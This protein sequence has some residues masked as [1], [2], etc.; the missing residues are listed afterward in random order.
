MVPPC[1]CKKFSVYQKES[2]KLQNAYAL[3]LR[4][5]NR[6]FLI[7]Q[8]HGK[9][10][11]YMILMMLYAETTWGNGGEMTARINDILC[12][13]IQYSEHVS[14]RRYYNIMIEFKYKNILY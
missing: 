4:N 8:T 13:I 14:V 3:K 9:L 1:L 7:P 12:L 10:C 6:S 5:P 2:T 11:I